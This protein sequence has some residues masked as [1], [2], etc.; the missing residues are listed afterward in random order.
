MP[1]KTGAPYDELAWFY[2][3][4]WGDFHAGIFP[5]IEELLLKNIPPGS[6]VLDL[7]CG[8][9]HL[10]RLLAFA[11]MR[12]YGTDLSAKMLELASKNVPGSAFFVSDARALA[13]KGSFDAVVSTFD[14][15]NHILHIEELVSVFRGVREILREGGLFV[16][17]MLLE[18]AY[19]EDWSESGFYLG[20]DNACLLSGGYDRDT[21]LA[22]ADITMFRDIEGWT[23]SDVRILERFYPARE[24][25]EALSGQGF[26]DIRFLDARKD[27]HLAGRFS[28]GRAF[29][30]ARRGNP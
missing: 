16:F 8:T 13:V 30:T 6:K 18:E 7:C 24:L 20:Q 9:G 1:K 26:P 10:S 3:K 22:H 15:L 11:G 28:R 12:V 2:E 19:I 17:D 25:F 4:Y 21:R 27:L 14:S 5:A 29:I 23:R